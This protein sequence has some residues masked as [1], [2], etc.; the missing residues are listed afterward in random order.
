LIPQKKQSGRLPPFHGLP[1]PKVI[2]EL[3]ELKEWVRLE[4]DKKM[5]RQTDEEQTLHE[6]GEETNNYAL[7]YEH[8]AQTVRDKKSVI[9]QFFAFIK[10][11]EGKQI[12]IRMKDLIEPCKVRGY[13]A[14][15]QK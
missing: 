11:M 5:Q 6:A 13:C 8:I 15:I 9:G 12:K 2:K 4:E 7:P 10:A 3:P 1:W 14:F